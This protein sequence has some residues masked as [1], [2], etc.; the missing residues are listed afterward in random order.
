MQYKTAALLFFVS[1]ISARTLDLPTAKAKLN[2]FTK[3]VAQIDEAIV[4]ITPAN[5][6]QQLDSISTQIKKI[7][8]ENAGTPQLLRKSKSLGLGDI[9]GF[10]GVVT[11]IL[12]TFQKTAND[13]LQKRDIINKVNGADKIEAA[14]KETYPV[15]AAVVDAVPSQFPAL[16]RGLIPAG[17]IPP[18]A[19]LEPM[20]AGLIGGMITTFKSNDTVTIPDAADITAALSAAPAALGNLGTG[21]ASS[22]SITA[23]KAGTGKTS[24][25]S[26]TAPKAS[27]GKGKS[28]RGKATLF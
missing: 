7:A 15:I 2:E 6:D 8:K 14:L 1:S 5:V 13:L 9:G 3:A 10:L 26:T 11:E 28:T 16:L 23:P 25:S 19:E 21:K 20:V 27:R 17:L 22:G 4:A 12:P 24:S 18:I